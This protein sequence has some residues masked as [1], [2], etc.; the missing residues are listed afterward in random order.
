MVMRELAGELK[1]SLLKLGLTPESASLEALE[2]ACFAA[3]IPRDRYFFSRERELPLKIQP[4]E[5]TARRASGEPLAYI[6]GE[7]DFYG[8]T[9]KTDRRALVP[10]DDSVSVLELFLEKLP[11]TAGEI[12]D[13]CTGT[14]CLGIAAAKA[15]ENIRAVLADLSPDALDLAKENCSLCGLADR[16]SVVPADAFGKPPFD[17]GVFGG[18]ICNPPYLRTDE[19]DMKTPEPLMALDGGE[20]GLNFYRAVASG[21]KRVLKPG[22]PLCFEVGM[23]QDAD[24]AEILKSEGFSGVATGKDLSGITRAVCA[25]K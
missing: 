23:G 3:G 19:L 15:R 24:V 5:L 16:V 14:G 10:R 13:L 21:W 1:N 8:I 2:L 4:E 22:A 20:D 11:E 12:L 25:F 17:D 9:L 6:I 18:M 7:W